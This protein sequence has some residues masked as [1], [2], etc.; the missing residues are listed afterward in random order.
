MTSP[1]D[2]REQ[3]AIPFT[4]DEIEPIADDGATYTAEENARFEAEARRERRAS[5]AVSAKAKQVHRDLLR[6]ERFAL[7]NDVIFMTFHE[8]LLASIHYFERFLWDYAPRYLTRHQPNPFAH[9]ACGLMQSD[10]L[11]RRNVARLR[12]LPPMSRSERRELLAVFDLIDQ[13]ARDEYEN[14]ERADLR[15]LAAKARRPKP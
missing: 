8:Q 11:H 4:L 10:E 3:V 1:K 6:L 13:T 2:N 15:K 9:E 12:F 14:P 7:A 5:L